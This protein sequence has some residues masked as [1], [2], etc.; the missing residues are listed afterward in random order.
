MQR[1]VVLSSVLGLCGLLACLS[2]TLATIPTQPRPGSYRTAALP[3]LRTRVRDLHAVDV[4]D[5]CAPSYQFCQTYAGRVTIT[6]TRTITG[7]IACAERWTTC[8]LTVAE[9]GISAEP[10]RDVRD[11]WVWRWQQWGD[12]FRRWVREAAWQQP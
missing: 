10:L 12:V 3:L 5:G 2:F 1:R 11:P 7:E 9:L 6:T 4:V 8:T